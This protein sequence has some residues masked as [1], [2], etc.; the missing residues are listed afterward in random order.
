MHP[1]PSHP[2]LLA[3]S[4]NHN[5]SPLLNGR[6]AS[7]E[8]GN[9]TQRQTLVS[10]VLI[11]ERGSQN[12]RS[13]IARGKCACDKAVDVTN[14]MGS[15]EPSWQPCTIRQLD[16]QGDRGLRGVDFRLGGRRSRCSRRS[17]GDWCWSRAGRRT[18]CGTA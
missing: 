6:S 17:S 4:R 5:S 13:L 18:W 14:G 15:V 16:S 3:P 7:L 1:I 12:P 11:R 2:L 10:V 9:I 8:L